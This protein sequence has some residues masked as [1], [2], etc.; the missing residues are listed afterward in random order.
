MKL[1][2]KNKHQRDENITFEESNHS[3]T[4]LTDLNSKYKSTTTW[5]GTHFKKFDAD[6]VIKRMRDTGSYKEKYEG[7]TD[8]EIKLKWENSGKQQSLNGTKMHNMIENFM[9]DILPNQEEIQCNIEWNYFQNYLKDHQ[10]PKKLIPY[11]TEWFI[12]NEDIKIC[13]SIDIAY[14]CEDGTIA[15][16]DWK[17]VSDIRYD[18]YGN[19]TAITECICDMPDTNFWHYSLQL[20]MYKYILETKYNKKVSDMALVVLHPSNDDWV[21]VPIPDLNATILDLIKLL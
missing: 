15:I 4:I 8:K 18:S 6:A 5:V 7:M 19:V 10:F 17:R 3:Y 11:R 16:Y 13:G 9:N 20:N 21:L 2:L 12:Y 1:A 14:E